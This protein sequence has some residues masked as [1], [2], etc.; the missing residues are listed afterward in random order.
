MDG[1][2]LNTMVK[3]AEDVIDYPF[4]DKELL[5]EALQ[6]AGSVKLQKPSKLPH[7]YNVLDR[8]HV[9]DV[10]VEKIEGGRTCDD[11]ACS[12][13]DGMG[14]SDTRKYSEWSPLDKQRLGAY[15]KEDKPWNIQGEIQQ[16]RARIHTTSLVEY[17]NGQPTILPCKAGTLP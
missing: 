13:E 10:W 15:K 5:W 2:R 14:R 16:P 11:D 1:N 4:I 12:S 17:R 6:A 8:F 7:Y 9:T 3:A